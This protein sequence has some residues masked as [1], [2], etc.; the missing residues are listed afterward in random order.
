LETAIETARS[1]GATRL[2]I[3][4]DPHAEDWYRKRGA[5]RLG[6]ASSGSIPGRLLLVLE[7]HL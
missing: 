7:H 5:E 2:E 4:A 3:E 1:A 6:E